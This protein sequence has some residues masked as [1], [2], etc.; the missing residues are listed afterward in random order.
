[1]STS[2]SKIS[3]SPDKK[4]SQILIPKIFVENLIFITFR[5]TLLTGVNG[6]AIHNRNKCISLCE[7][8]EY[9]N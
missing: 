6:G 1:M 2:G 9:N 4:I 3:P 5:Y 7:N 8:N